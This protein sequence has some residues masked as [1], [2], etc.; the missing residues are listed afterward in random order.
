MDQIILRTSLLR[1]GVDAPPLE[2][3]NLQ[4]FEEK[5]SATVC[6]FPGAGSLL[7]PDSAE[8]DFP[9]LELYLLLLLLPGILQDLM[10][11]I[12]GNKAAKA[13]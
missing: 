10:D 5:Q 11:G 13:K 2:L 12:P 4:E 9:A 8:A 1:L 3:D 7:L 6:V